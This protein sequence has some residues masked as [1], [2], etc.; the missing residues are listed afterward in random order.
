MFTNQVLI[1]TPDSLLG[2]DALYDPP[3]LM[4]S[5]ATL[6]VPSAT[7]TPDAE[8]QQGVS[9]AHT[10]PAPT[11][12]SDTLPEPSQESP[13]SHSAATKPASDKHAGN[14]ASPTAAIEPQTPDLSAG[15]QNGP[16]SD[17][18]GSEKPND[19]GSDASPNT[20]GSTTLKDAESN[21]SSNT[22]DGPPA[23]GANTSRSH[24]AM[25]ESQTPEWVPGSQGDGSSTTASGSLANNAS[26]DT[27]SDSASAS[28][29]PNGTSAGV[30]LVS[31]VWSYA[32]FTLFLL[33]SYFI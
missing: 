18:A 26:T 13:D 9:T 16:S 31:N 21:D 8:P 22:V 14:T 5:E 11:A 23:N 15:T 17:S 32:A 6:D 30:N 25:M 7:I 20:A 28:A 10:T 27:Q 24:T 2:L 3:R 12:A 4:V 29:S 33:L 19:A 1:L